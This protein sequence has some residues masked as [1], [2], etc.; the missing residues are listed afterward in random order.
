MQ[1]FMSG[2]QQRYLKALASTDVTSPIRMD[3]NGRRMTLC[4]L[5]AISIVGAIA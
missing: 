4:C 1:T 3:T 2:S 5:P